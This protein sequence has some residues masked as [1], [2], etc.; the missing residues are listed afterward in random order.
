MCPSTSISAAIP[1]SVTAPAPARATA[2]LTSTSIST[3]SPTS[4]AARPSAQ[5]SP[6]PPALRTRP[7]RPFSSSPPARCCPRATLWTLW[8]ACPR[9]ACTGWTRPRSPTSPVRCGARPSRL[10]SPSS[11]APSM[12][13]SPSSSP[14]CRLSTWPPATQASRR[15][16]RPCALPPSPLT[17]SP[18]GLPTPASSRRTP[19]TPPIFAT[20]PRTSRTTPPRARPPTST[21]TRSSPAAARPSR[22]PKAR[23]RKCLGRPT[24]SPGPAPPPATSKRG[25]RGR[26]QMRFVC[27]DIGAAP[28]TRA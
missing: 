9:K 16:P 14:W 17:T 7:R 21:S 27:G 8:R 6:S 22:S 10:A 13:R 25:V 15:C 26:T 3:Q 12:G 2:F 11:S 20:L 5:R 24:T 23:P 18:P 4:R 1:R 28:Y 19:R